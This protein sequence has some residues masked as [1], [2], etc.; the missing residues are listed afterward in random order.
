MVLAF[1]RAASPYPLAELSLRGLDA[2]GRYEVSSDRTGKRIQ[3]TGAE[4]TQRFEITLPKRHSSD[5]IVYR[6]VPE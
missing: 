6:R 1:R 5:L 3:R 2:S 4:L